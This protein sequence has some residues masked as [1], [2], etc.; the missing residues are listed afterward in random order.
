[1]MQKYR[2][3]KLA[4]SNAP[5]AKSAVSIEEY[6]KDF[7]FSPPVDYYIEGVLYDTEPK[8]GKPLT[9]IRDNRNGV[10]CMGVMKTS[11]IV[12]IS[13]HEDGISQ[14]IETNNSVYILETV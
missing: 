9:V 13:L 1:M 7:Q 5:F 11:P 8:V 3:T 2:L 4:A 10:K 14:I 6:R 12:E